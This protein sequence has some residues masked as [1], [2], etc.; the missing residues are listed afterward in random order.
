MTDLLALTEQ[1]CAVPSVSGAEAALADLVEARLRDRAVDLD[2]T[3]LG[4][5]VVART[6]RGGASRIVLGG[7]L[8]TVPVN[9]NATPRRD[10]D[11][12]HGLGSADRKGGLAVMLELAEALHVVGEGN[13]PESFALFSRTLD[14]DWVRRVLTA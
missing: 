3:R 4:A 12:L 11:T 7:H 9:G 5:N 13:R 10:G 14:M 1:L 8:D 6:E 2:I